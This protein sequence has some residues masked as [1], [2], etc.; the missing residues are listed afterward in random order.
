MEK[1]IVRRL[2]DY[3]SDAYGAIGKLKAE[4]AVAAS[5]S[6]A[7]ERAEHYCS[8]V[9]PAMDELRA[10]VDGMEVIVSSELWPVPTYGDM[11]FRV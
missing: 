6:D 7:A 1:D 10:A 3:V 2:S 11:M 9:I 5:I 4:E 8:R